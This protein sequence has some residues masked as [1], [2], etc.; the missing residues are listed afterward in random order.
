MSLHRRYKFPGK[1]QRAPTLAAGFIIEAIEPC[2]HCHGVPNMERPA[3]DFDP[4]WS[5]A[6]VC[7]A[8]HGLGYMLL[9]GAPGVEISDGTVIPER[10]V[11]HVPQKRR[12]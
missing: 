3:N 11:G 4:P 6:G 7:D 5:Q 8:C 1:F 12:S 2:I 10:P 9:G